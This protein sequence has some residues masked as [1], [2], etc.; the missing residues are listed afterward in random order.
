VIRSSVITWAT[1]VKDY[2]SQYSAEG[3]SAS[4]ALGPPDVYPNR[5]DLPD[6]WASRTPDGGIETLE[7]TF[8]TE[9]PT[10]SIIIVET[11]NPGAVV[12]IDDVTPGR[13]PVTIWEGSPAPYQSPRMLLV[14]LPQ[15]RKITALRLVL[16]SKSTPGWNQI[17]AVG[18]AADGKPLDATSAPRR[19]FPP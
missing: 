8:D 16:D 13:S 5:G 17:D 2:S 4:R 14:S 3:W 9:L 10:R 12:R 15:A 1:G 7:L 18:L 19:V 11:H 6:A